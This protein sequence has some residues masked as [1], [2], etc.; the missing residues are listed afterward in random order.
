[1]GSSQ[2]LS[3]PVCLFLAL[4]TWVEILGRPPASLGAR[5]VATV[6]FSLL[7]EGSGHWCTPT[8]RCGSGHT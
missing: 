1:M 3:S 5:F 7:I 6:L 2:T 4:L 8:Q